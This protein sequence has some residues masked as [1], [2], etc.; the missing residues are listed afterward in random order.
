[1]TV[2]FW[3]KALISVGNRQ[4]PFF[5]GKTKIMNVLD[6][7]S[8]PK[9][10]KSSNIDRGMV[11]CFLPASIRSKN[12]LIFFFSSN[13][14]LFPPPE[15]KTHTKK[16]TFFSTNPIFHDQKFL[17]LL[18]VKNRVLGKKKSLFWVFFF[19]GK[20]KKT[21]SSFTILLPRMISWGNFRAS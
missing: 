7:F 1:M 12:V 10:N 15:K 8:Y 2:S 13:F 6:I 14:F 5:F 18:V 21:F 4:T 16:A 11:V 20:I 19:R 9:C 17:K 3:Y